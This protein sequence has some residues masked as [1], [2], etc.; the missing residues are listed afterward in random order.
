VSVLGE[1]A[2][3]KYC[4]DGCLNRDYI[5][6]VKRVGIYAPTV[7]SGTVATENESD[8]DEEDEGEGGDDDYA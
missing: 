4:R 1:D 7:G 8:G 5:R 2:L 3:K 6:K